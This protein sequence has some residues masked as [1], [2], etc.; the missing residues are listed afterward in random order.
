MGRHIHVSNNVPPVS[1]ESV[2]QEGDVYWSRRCNSQKLIF[3]GMKHQGL[4]LMEVSLQLQLLE[5]VE[6]LLQMMLVPLKDGL[7]G[8]KFQLRS[9][10]TVASMMASMQV[11]GGFE[12]VVADEKD[13]SVERVKQLIQRIYIDKE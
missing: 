9:G 8:N 11:D 4:K 6:I 2:V 3:L 5:K 13:P 12:L 7:N 1:G 10:G